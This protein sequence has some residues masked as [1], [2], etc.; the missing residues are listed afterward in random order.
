MELTTYRDGIFSNSDPIA[1]PGLTSFN[2]GSLGSSTTSFRDGLFSQADPMA[3][4]GSLLTSYSDGSL[5]ATSKALKSPKSCV[6]WCMGLS[7][8]RK[9]AKCI[10]SCVGAANAAAASNPNAARSRQNLFARKGGVQGLG[11]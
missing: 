6:N 7:T 11:V 3:Y 8:R 10:H 9:R 1:S 5:G 2:D 4:P